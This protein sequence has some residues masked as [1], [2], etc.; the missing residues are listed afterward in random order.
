[1]GNIEFNIFAAR[2]MI[3]DTVNKRII[4]AKNTINEEMYIRFMAEFFTAS[5][6]AGKNLTTLEFLTAMTF[7]R[8]LSCF[9]HIFPNMN[10]TAIEAIICVSQR[11]QPTELLFHIPIPT[12]PKTN[13]G[14]A[15]LLNESILSASVFVH[16]LFSYKD[17]AVLAPTG[18]PDIRPNIKAAE[19]VPFT[20]KTGLII[21]PKIFPKISANPNDT[22]N[23]EKTK[24]GNNV[25]IIILIHRSKASAEALSDSSGDATSPTRPATAISINIYFLKKFTP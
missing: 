14:P 20:L 4:I 7:S 18:N 22:A 15:L 23:D 17:I 8:S 19:H 9:F 1:M 11:V 3:P 2:G 5:V 13:A 25:G 12:V 6:I 24:K 21:W 10:P 16:K